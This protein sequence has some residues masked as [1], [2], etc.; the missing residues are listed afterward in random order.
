[1]CLFLDSLIV[2]CRL[3]F[4]ALPVL[5][6]FRI[7]FEEGFDQKAFQVHILRKADKLRISILIYILQI[8]ANNAYSL[9]TIPLR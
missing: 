8:K 1:M 5:R 2:R 3:C 6:T 9:I 7:K 4:V